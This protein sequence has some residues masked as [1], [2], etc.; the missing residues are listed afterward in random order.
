MR[1]RV[2]VL[3]LLTSVQLLSAGVVLPRTKLFVKDLCVIH[4]MCEA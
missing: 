2:C 1:E 3:F 4:Y